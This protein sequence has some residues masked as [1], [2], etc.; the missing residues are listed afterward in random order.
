MNIPTALIEKLKNAHHVVIFT[1]AGVSAESGIP[2]FRDDMTG[3]WQNFSAEKLATEQ[4]FLE[5]PALVWGWYEWRRHKVLQAQPNPAHQVIAKLSALY[6]K[7]TVVTQN[8]D[9]L[10]ERAGSQNVLHLHGSLHQGR[11]IRCF[12]AYQHVES[13]G[14]QDE[15]KIEPPRCEHCGDLIRPSVVWFGETLPF[16]IVTQAEDEAAI[17]DVMLI[18]GTSALV[19]P[20]ANIPWLAIKYKPTTVQINMTPNALDSR[21][22][23]N[24]TGK[25][26]EILPLLFEALLAVKQTEAEKNSDLMSKLKNWIR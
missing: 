2:T 23:F 19:Y 11:C 21:V 6:S 15:C 12:Q 25:A 7:F 26:G 16:D 5:D 17:C 14:I 20:A 8:V 10:H 9:D 3:F 13:V 22:D 24:L 1:G 18:I 4:G